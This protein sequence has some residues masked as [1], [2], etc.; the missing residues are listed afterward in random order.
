VTFRDQPRDYLL[1]RLVLYTQCPPSGDFRLKRCTAQAQVF[2][3]FFWLREV[4]DFKF[5]H[6]ESIHEQFSKLT[7]ARL[8]EIVISEGYFN[9][10]RSRTRESIY[11]AIKQAVPEIQ[12]AI[13]NSVLDEIQENGPRSSS[14]R[15]VVLNNMLETTP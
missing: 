15:Y 9:T 7:V 8:R 5:H 13:Y 12:D 3:F 11:N 1:F 6:G 14:T 2:E 10:S 4:T